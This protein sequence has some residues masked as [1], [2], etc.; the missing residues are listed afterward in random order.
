[1]DLLHLFCA[2]MVALV[3]LF[4]INMLNLAVTGDELYAL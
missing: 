1:M 4:D 2:K 3:I